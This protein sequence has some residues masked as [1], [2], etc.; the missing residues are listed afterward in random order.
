MPGDILIIKNRRGKT[1]VKITKSMRKGHCPPRATLVINFK[2]YKDLALF[3]HD[4]KDLYDAPVD[5]AIEEYKAGR[6][7]GWPF[8]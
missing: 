4:L 8:S 1:H 2:N 3:F 5:K 6:T 7:S